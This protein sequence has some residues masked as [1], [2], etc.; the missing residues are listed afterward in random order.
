MVHRLTM[1]IVS[2]NKEKKQCLLLSIVLNLGVRKLPRL[3]L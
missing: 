2:H 3:Q 1:V